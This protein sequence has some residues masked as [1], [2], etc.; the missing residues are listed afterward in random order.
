MRMRFKTLVAALAIALNILPPAVAIDLIVNGSF[1]NNTGLG[2]IGYN[3]TVSGWANS[4]TPAFGAPKAFNFLVDSNVD[5]TGVPYYFGP[6]NFKLW[7]PGSGVNNGFTGSSDGGN[8]IASAAGYGQAAFVQTIN[9]LTPGSS[10][11][12]DYE[13]AS[14]QESGYY[15]PTTD[16]WTVSLGSESY[17][18]PAFNLL[19]QGFSGWMNRSETFTATSTSET[20][21]F[22]AKGSPDSLPPF[23]LLDG[24]RLSPVSVPEPSTMAMGGFATLLVGLMARRRRCRQARA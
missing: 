10:Y 18:S 8:F 9:G 11:K 6:P 17:D 1:E 5:S 14:A 3:T 23:L 12:L 2:Q 16:Y 24:V 21:T 15:G 4:G 20:L 19:S 13:W 7:G 22:L